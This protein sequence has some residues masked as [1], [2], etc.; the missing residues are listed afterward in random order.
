MTQ[1]M[2]EDTNGIIKSVQFLLPL[3]DEGYII[4]GNNVLL[5]ANADSLPCL[6][7]APLS[8]GIWKFAGY[9]ANGTHDRSMPPFVFVF[10][11]LS[12]RSCRSL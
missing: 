1:S 5:L 4:R 3:Q 7:S 2:Q 6:V 9:F 12:S 8:S 10:L 11:F